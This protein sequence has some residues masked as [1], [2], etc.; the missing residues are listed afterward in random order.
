MAQSSHGL[1]LARTDEDAVNQDCQKLSQSQT[2]PLERRLNADLC[3][4][5]ASSAQLLTLEALAGEGGWLVGLSRKSW[6]FHAGGQE[7]DTTGGVR[8]RWALCSLSQS[9][10]ALLL[11]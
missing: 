2:T 5:A 4:T 10:A 6:G 7:G 1:S 9:S 3:L 11:P 8:W